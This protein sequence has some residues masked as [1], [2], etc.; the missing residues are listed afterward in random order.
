MIDAC[1]H[2]VRALTTDTCPVHL[3]T[4]KDQ[5]EL[6]STDIVGSL[7]KPQNV[8]NIQVLSQTPNRS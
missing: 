7:A 5:L 2:F 4:L 8:T 3:L 1:F 6:V